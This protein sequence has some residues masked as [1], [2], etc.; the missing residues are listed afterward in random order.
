MPT[1][2]LTVASQDEEL[3]RVQ[4]NLRAAL[5]PV[6]RDLLLNRLQLTADITTSDTTIQHSLGRVPA[7]WIVIDK[8]ANADI[9]RVSLTNTTIVLRA[10]ASV[11]AKIFIF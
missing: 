4:S 5:D 2:F 10:S 3:N 11:K 1:P 9:W 8:N 7:G 6:S